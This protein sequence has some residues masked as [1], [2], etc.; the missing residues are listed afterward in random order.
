MDNSTILKL[1][2]KRFLLAFLLALV[3]IWAGSEAAYFFLKDD[4]DRAPEQIELLIPDGTALK[5]ASGEPVPSIPDEMVFVL[6]DTL[7]VKNEDIV[8]HQL[9]PLWIPAKSRASLLLDNADRY[10]YQCSFRPS[11][12][13]GVNVKQGTTWNT[14]L[15]ALLYSVPA[16]TMF[17]FIYSLVLWP[18]VPKE[19]DKKDLAE[20]LETKGELLES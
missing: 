20:K 9:G 3:L 18:L 7:V 4:T 14:R 6:G 2:L 12:Y 11:Q 13:L 1:G 10:A 15:T 19:A 16:T 17:F 8:D 5:V